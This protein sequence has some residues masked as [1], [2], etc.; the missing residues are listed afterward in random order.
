MSATLGSECAIAMAKL[1]RVQLS[2]TGRC[3]TGTSFASVGAAIGSSRAT[4]SSCHRPPPH[5]PLTEVPQGKNPASPV[6][7]VG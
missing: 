1:S 6:R 2:T 4:N 5:P 3:A 7:K